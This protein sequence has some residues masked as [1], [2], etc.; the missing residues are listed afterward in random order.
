MHPRSTV[1]MFSHVSL[2]WG[3]GGGESPP[4]NCLLTKIQHA[5]AG[6]VCIYSSFHTIYMDS[7]DMHA[8]LKHLT[9]AQTPCGMASKFN[10]KLEFLE[11]FSDN[12]E[13]RTG[14]MAMMNIKVSLCQSCALLPKYLPEYIG[15]TLGDLA[16]HH[17]LFM[18]KLAP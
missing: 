2:I 14:R 1:L 10:P 17:Y 12:T 11:S 16:S 8:K 4:E 5:A 13:C 7:G 18:K 9:S 6:G 15:S 3:G